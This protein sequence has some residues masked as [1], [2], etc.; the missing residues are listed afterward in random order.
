M[1]AVLPPRKGTI[2]QV[3]RSRSASEFSTRQLWSGTEVLKRCSA[4]T[5]WGRLEKSD[6]D[7]VHS[8]SLR[9]I[10]ALFTRC[11]ASRGREGA[12]RRPLLPGASP[13]CCFRAQPSPCT[14]TPQAGAEWL[15]FLAS[16]SKEK[17]P[18]EMK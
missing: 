4:D 12:A 5:V 17:C 7:S 18:R 9:S 11:G 2:C 10:C 1:L 6:A 8:R 15:L 14:G 3:V 13:V 16:E